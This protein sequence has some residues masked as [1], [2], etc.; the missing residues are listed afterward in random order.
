M[1]FTVYAGDNAANTDNKDNTDNTIKNDIVLEAMKQELSRSM[2]TLAEKGT[3]PYFISYLVRDS[4]RMSTSASFGALRISG[5]SHSRVLDV[6]VRVGSHKLDNTHSIRGRHFGSDS[7]HS[8]PFPISLEDDPEAIKNAIWMETDKKYKEAVEKLIQIEANKNVR[9]EEEDKSNDFS[10]EEPQQYLEKRAAISA[11][12]KAWESKIKEYSTLFSGY[13][14]IYGSEVSI[15]AVAAN[16]Y[17]VN[18]EGT[19]LR[20]G[21]THWRLTVSASTKAED[22]MQL[23]KHESFNARQLENLPGEDI[24]KPVIRQMIEDLLALRAASLME[25]FTGPA[26][27]SGKASAVFFHEI[28]GH[29]VEGHRQKDEKEGQ[30]FTKQINKKVLP[31]FISMYDDPTIKEYANVDL[32]GHYLYDEEGVKSQRVDLVKNG[33]LRNFLMSRSPIEGF[34]KSNGHGRAQAGKQP[35]SRQGN[36]VIESSKTVSMK[37]L[38]QMLIEECKKQGKTYGL[39]F[40]DITGGFTFTQRY[41]RQAFNVTPIMV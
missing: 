18:S 23:F 32:N 2:K 28:F 9:V 34:P 20:H 22:G 30:T 12:L 15:L 37:K 5:S 13:P 17:F 40:E 33:I 26:I 21:R 11:D 6:E 14:D 31:E 35:V 7:G 19:M 4:K 16:K 3:P 39:F 41:M 24:V 1:F 25:P 10:S 36:L 29:R 8:F 27:L 38:K